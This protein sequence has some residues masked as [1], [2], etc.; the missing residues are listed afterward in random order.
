MGGGRR[1]HHRHSM[2]MGRR[3]VADNYGHEPPGP[4]GMGSGSPQLSRK[5]RI[6]PAYPVTMASPRKLNTRVHFP[7]CR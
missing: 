3:S 2:T 4:S 7:K 6:P 5:N 1:E